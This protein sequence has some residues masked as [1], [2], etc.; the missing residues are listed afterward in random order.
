MSFTVNKMYL[1]ANIVFAA[2]LLVGL[3]TGCGKGSGGS[4]NAP[5]VTPVGPDPNGGDSSS[6]LLAPAGSMTVSPGKVIGAGR[7]V[8][9]S[10]TIGLGG[11]KTLSSNTVMLQMNI[12]R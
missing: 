4:A 9:G 11:R 10:A 8:S 12:H 1:K 2:A 3:M 7:Y 6:V 5:S